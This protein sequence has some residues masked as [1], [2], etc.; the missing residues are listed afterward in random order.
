[1]RKHK[2]KCQK[3]DLFLSGDLEDR[4]RWITKGQEEIDEYDGILQHWAERQR[5]SACLGAV[6]MWGQNHNTNTSNGS[7]TRKG[8][9]G[10]CSKKYQILC[11]D[12]HRFKNTEKHPVARHKQKKLQNTKTKKIS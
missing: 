1:M 2:P 8:G 4:R 10:E 3:A 7:S 9:R 5:G 11:L 12:R 6:E